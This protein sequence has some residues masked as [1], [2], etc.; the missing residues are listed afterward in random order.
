MS[1]DNLNAEGKRPR[2]QKPQWFWETAIEDP[3]GCI[4]E[5][6]RWFH[7]SDL[8]GELNAWLRIALIN[9]ESAYDAGSAREDVMDFCSELQLLTE[10]LHV[11]NTNRQPG[12]TRRWE[13]GLPNDL[14]K[15]INSYNLPIML[16]DEQKAHPQFVI[17]NFRNTFSLSYTRRELWDLLD[18]VAYYRKAISVRSSEPHVTYRCLLALAEAA[19]VLY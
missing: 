2:F 10:A 18:A 6:F 16:T 12:G 14:R 8:R 19:F 1:G 15:E 3:Y 9:D 4:A 11:V 17:R 13:E 5:V 7:P